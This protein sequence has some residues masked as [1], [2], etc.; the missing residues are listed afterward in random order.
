MP[1]GIDWQAT[2]VDREQGTPYRDVYKIGT[3]W[4]S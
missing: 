3:K 1:A 4:T 2:H